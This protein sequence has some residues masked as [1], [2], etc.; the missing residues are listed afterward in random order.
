MRAIHII[1]NALQLLGPSLAATIPA[2]PSLTLYD[3]A[4]DNLTFPPNSTLF[5]HVNSPSGVR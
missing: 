5:L 2:T 1:I 4:D 3:S